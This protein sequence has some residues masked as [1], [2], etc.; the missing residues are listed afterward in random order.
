VIGHGQAQ[1]V[2]LF[3]DVDDDSRLRVLRG[4]GEQLAALK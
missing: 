3:G 2:L 1:D 4:V